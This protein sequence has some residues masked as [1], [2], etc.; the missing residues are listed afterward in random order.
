MY[1]TAMSSIISILFLTAAASLVPSILSAQSIRPYD[2]RNYECEIR[3]DIESHGITGEETI[4]LVSRGEPLAMVELDAAEIDVTEAWQ[5]GSACRV[6]QG[7][8]R[9]MITLAQGVP[10][11]GRCTLR[12]RYMGVP[13]RGMKFLP[14]QIRTAFH[15]GHWMVCNEDPADK[16]T[17]TLHLVVPGRFTVVAAGSNIAHEMLEEGMQRTSWRLDRPYPAYLYGFVAGIFSDTSLYAGRVRLRMLSAG[18]SPGEMARMF[19]STAPALDFFARRS[20]IPFPDSIYTQ[21]L[22]NGPS[23]QEAATYSWLSEKYAEEVLAEPREDWLVAHE[24][25]HQWWGNLLTCATWSDMWL[26]EG[27]ATFMTAAFKEHHWSREEYEREMLLCRFRYERQ[28]AEGNDRPLHFT[29][30]TAPEEANGPIAYYKGAAVLHLLRYHLGEGSFWEGIR[31]Y[32][33]DNAEGNA[34]SRDLQMAMEMESGEDLT[35]FFQH[36]VYTSQSPELTASFSERE[37]EVVVEIIQRRRTPWT[38][39]IQIAV[40]TGDRRESRRVILAGART[41]ARFSVA[42][43]LLSVRVDDG[44]HFPMRIEYER[45]PAMLR[46]QALR[47]PD[48]AGR[49]EALQMLARADSAMRSDES[50]AMLRSIAMTDSSRIVRQVASGMLEQMKAADASKPE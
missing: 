5:E 31:R 46:H 19:A 20:G 15:T 43:P 34:G 41:V 24:L 39:P 25:A 22:V 37:G 48:V 13:G 38:F 7:G 42:S 30:W 18:K 47:E 4:E 12:L 40:E 28:R 10:N 26:N 33:R 3:L 8:E 49:V 2:V 21:V 16:A 23:G 27:F 9:V 50:I 29:G 44:G 6:E 11:G 17:M 14:D 36:W 1:R 45:P 32:T 35:A